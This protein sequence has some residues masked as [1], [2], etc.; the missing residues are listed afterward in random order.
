MANS[1][2]L[3]ALTRE[4]IE[5]AFKKTK[6]ETNIPGIELELVTE[7]YYERVFEFAW[8]HFALREPLYTA[9]CIERTD[10]L[11]SIFM[12]NYKFNL[13]LIFIDKESKEIIA[14]RTIRIACKDDVSDLDSIKS[15]SIRDLHA[16][17]AY[18]DKLTDFFGHYGVTEAFF[19]HGL[20][21]HEKYGRRGYGE[22]ICRAAINMIRH[23]GIDPVY[24]KGETSSKY[25][26]KV[27]SNIG[28]EE[29]LEV[30]YDSYEIDGRK[31]I[32]NTGIHESQKMFGMIVNQNDGRD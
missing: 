16:F 31:P 10:E 3:K 28:F 15:Q 5:K 17:D 19:F 30:R 12:S 18:C 14:L 26:H 4:Q 23:F 22:K 2:V 9:L 1:S 8:N 24:I 21:V 29:L 27:Y 32:Q 25:G 13:S 6:E 7:K 20:A 11:K